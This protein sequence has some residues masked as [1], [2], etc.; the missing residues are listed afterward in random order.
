MYSHVRI[1]SKTKLRDFWTATPAQRGARK[2]LMIWHDIVA[3][4]AW[5]SPADVKEV[6]GVNVDLVKVDSGNTV[7][8]FD[9][10]GNKYRL[11]AAIHFLQNHPEHGRVYVLRILT[12]AEYDREA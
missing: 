3:G 8:V 2:P 10:H 11:I 6:F 4:A 12:H 7:Y 5:R 1:I 9:I